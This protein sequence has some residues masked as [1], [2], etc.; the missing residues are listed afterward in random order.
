MLPEDHICF[1]EQLAYF[2]QDVSRASAMLQAE[3]KCAMIWI[4]MV[5]YLCYFIFDSLARHSHHGQMPK[6]QFE[7]FYGCRQ[8][9]IPI[10]N[11]SID[12]FVLQLIITF[13]LIKIYKRNVFFFLIQHMIFK[14]HVT[15]YH[16]FYQI[17]NSRL[18]NYWYDCTPNDTTFHN[19]FK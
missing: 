10:I 1:C 7:F 13:I 16:K 17:N 18:L 14:S 15:S 12:L 4:Y 9:L 19:R 3:K 2:F 6:I 11:N 5:D 8:N